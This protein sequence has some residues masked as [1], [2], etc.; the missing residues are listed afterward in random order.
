MY[1]DKRGKTSVV[2]FKAANSSQKELFSPFNQLTGL[3]RDMHQ[4]V[5]THHLHTPQTALGAYSDILY[6][7]D[8]YSDDLYSDDLHSDDQYS[9]DLYMYSDD[10]HSD[11]ASD[12]LTRVDYEEVAQAVEC[13]TVWQK[14]LW[15][16]TDLFMTCYGCL[17]GQM[18]EMLQKRLIFGHSHQKMYIFKLSLILH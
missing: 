13:Y 17:L 14:I 12:V 8:L 11:N 10:L 6:S 5:W 1:Y 2:H 16:S 4:D 3:Q 15:K 9:D 18:K 7:D